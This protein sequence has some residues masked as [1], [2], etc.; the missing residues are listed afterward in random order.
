M[1]DFQGYGRELPTLR[2]PG[3]AALAV[4]FVLNFE[5]GAEFS[6]ADGDAH[7]EGVYEVIDPRA[8]WD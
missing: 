8:G 5:E 2:W 3:G 7:N 1:R 6:V 4:S